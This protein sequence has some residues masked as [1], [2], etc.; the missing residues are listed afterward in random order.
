MIASCFIETMKILQEAA[1]LNSPIVIRQ[2]Q[3]VRVSFKLY[4]QL[5]N[6]IISI[7]LLS[8]RSLKNIY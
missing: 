8:E 2:I 1:T 7:T 3:R 4:L 6:A 5:L